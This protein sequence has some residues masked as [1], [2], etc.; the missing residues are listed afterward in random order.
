MITSSHELRIHKSHSK[1]DAHTVNSFCNRVIDVWN[2]HLFSCQVHLLSV[3]PLTP[4][5]AIWVQL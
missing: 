3:N 5:V 4:T 2:N 1:V